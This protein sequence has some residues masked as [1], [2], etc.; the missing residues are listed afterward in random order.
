MSSRTARVRGQDK[1]AV[2]VRIPPANGL[3]N[4]ELC[5]IKANA[6][7][8]RITTPTREIPDLMTDVAGLDLSTLAEPVQAISLTGPR[9]W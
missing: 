8:S 3:G 2:I 1:R 6:I 9:K 4:G 5:R 7:P